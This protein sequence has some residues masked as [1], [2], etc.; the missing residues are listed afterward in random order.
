MSCEREREREREKVVFVNARII[1]ADSST[2]VAY[3]YAPAGA[4]AY[5]L[6]VAAP[7]PDFQTRD[8]WCRVS[9]G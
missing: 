5:E 3:L 2:H 4:F 9:P 8:T 7:F 6:R 1:Y